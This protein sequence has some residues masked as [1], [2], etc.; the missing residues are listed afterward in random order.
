MAAEVQKGGCFAV[1]AALF[2]VAFYGFL[3]QPF[4]LAYNNMSRLPNL[5]DTKILVL[6]FLYL[7]DPAELDPNVRLCYSCIDQTDTKALVDLA[8]YTNVPSRLKANFWKSPY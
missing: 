6:L 2:K 4:L 8:L 5:S 1:F 3:R 7:W